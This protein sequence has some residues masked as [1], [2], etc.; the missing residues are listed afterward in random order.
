MLPDGGRASGGELGGTGGAN[1]TGGGSSTTGGGSA[2]TMQN[3]NSTFH[4]IVG[5][6]AKPNPAEAYQP[7]EGTVNSKCSTA[8]NPSMTY[9]DLSRAT[10]GLRF[11]MCQPNLYGTVFEAVAQGVIASAQVACDF[12]VPPPPQGFSL[13]NRISVAYTPGAGGAPTEFLQVANSGACAAN[14]F[15]VQNG[16]VIFC[17]QTCSSV[18]MD[19][20]ARVAVRFTCEPMIQ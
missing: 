2:G 14:S 10:K 4:A 18:R 16:R 17:P 20:L 3:R 15:S 5:V 11:Q 19:A 1:G 12:A 8:V 6:A 9:Q 7:N 13:S